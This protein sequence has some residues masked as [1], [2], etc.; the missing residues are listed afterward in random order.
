MRCTSYRSFGTILD[1]IK[2]FVDNS[3]A[4]CSFSLLCIPLYIL[5]G[6]PYSEMFVSEATLRVCHHINGNPVTVEPTLSKHFFLLP[7]MRRF[8]HCYTVTCQSSESFSCESQTWDVSSR[9]CPSAGLHQALQH[10]PLTTGR[11][12]IRF[13]A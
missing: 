11:N 13:L 9:E 2:H 12:D 8:P 1:N 7:P 5:A 4:P 10:L 3:S 6:R